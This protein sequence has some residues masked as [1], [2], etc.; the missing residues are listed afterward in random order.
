MADD[1]LLEAAE[2]ESWPRNE[3]ARIEA[4]LSELEIELERRHEA[5]GIAGRLEPEAV[6]FVAQL[7][8][9][10]PVERKSTRT[11][12]WSLIERE[13]RSRGDRAGE[14]YSAELLAVLAWES[15]D[16]RGE[17]TRGTIVALLDTCSIRHHE[18]PTGML[19]LRFDSRSAYDEFR[20]RL[21][22]EM[23]EDTWP[24]AFGVTHAGPFRWVYGPPSESSA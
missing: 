11:A 15:K 6:E 12:I 2:R 1:W 3:I 24:T 13:R 5:V 16:P 7:V 21:E 9:A 22:D 8:D 14:R 17:R 18:G 23:L 20:L 10:P 4:A 19:L